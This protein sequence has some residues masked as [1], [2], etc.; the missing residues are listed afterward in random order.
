MKNKKIK[1]LTLIELICAFT[2]FALVSGGIATVLLNASATSTRAHRVNMAQFEAQ[3]QLERIMGVEWTGISDW[4]EIIIDMI[5]PRTAVMVTEETP[6]NAATWGQRFNMNGFSIRI[7]SEPAT[8]WGEVGPHSEGP[9]VLRVRIYVY[10]TPRC[11]EGTHL[12]MLEG[13]IKVMGEFRQLTLNNSRFYTNPDMF[14]PPLHETGRGSRV[15]RIYFRVRDLFTGEEFYASI[16]AQH[17]NV[18]VSGT[19]TFNNGC[20]LHGEAVEVDIRDNA[21][22]I[23]VLRFVGQ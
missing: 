1:G 9:G 6:E 20:R 18:N 21:R 5:F 3:F 16:M 2:I 11:E 22:T 4:E 23:R 10:D 17:P 13:A 14:S 19:F 7:D 15:W 8:S 12:A